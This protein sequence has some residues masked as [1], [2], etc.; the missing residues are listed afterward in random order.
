MY[1]LIGDIHGHARPL[2]AL[3]EKLDYCEDNRGIWRHPERKIIFLGDFVDRGPEQVEVVRI[4][5]SM[6]ESGSAL[7]VM[8]NH[9]FNAVAWTI[10]DSESPGEFLRPHS[11]KNRKQHQAFLDQF[12]DGSAKHKECIEWFRTL[13]LYLDLPGLRVVHACWHTSSLQALQPFLDDQG[14]IKPDCWDQLARKGGAGFEL[15]EILLKGLEAPLPDDA[16]FKDKDGNIRR[17]VRMKW[18]WDLL[19]EKELTWRDLAMLPSEQLDL[20]PHTPA[21]EDVIP[22]YQDAKPVFVGHYWMTG[23]PARLTEKVACLDYSIAA[24]KPGKLVVYR[25]NGEGEIDNA[26]FEYVCRE[27]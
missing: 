14:C 21:P 2:I 19:G 17:H 12:G 22:G 26:Q 18:W 16:W 5:R 4:A 3:L 10:P 15:A 6:V 24:K 13:P 20:L 11:E 7:S 25:W 27:F 23:Q 1:D 8:G 9:E